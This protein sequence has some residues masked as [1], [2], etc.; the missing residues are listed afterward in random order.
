MAGSVSFDRAAAAYDQTRPLPE[1][2]AAHAIEVIL[3]SVGCDARLL[4]VGTG[5]G[6][7]SRPLLERGANLVGVD[8]SAQMLRR[9]QAKRPSA[10][11]AQAHARYLPFAAGSFDA[12]LTVHV[13]HVVGPWR[14]ALREFRRVLRP[15]G[16]YLDAKTYESVGVSQRGRIR[17]FWRGFMAAQGI[18]ARHP[19]VQSQEEWVQ[20]LRGLGA[21]VTEVEAARYALSFPLREELE[22]YETRVYSDTWKI[23]DAIFAAS[24]RE[25]RGWMAGKYGSL[26]YRVDDTVRCVVYVAR[27]EE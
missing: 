3:A 17:K 25:L 18:D 1:P 19:G 20:A 13:M 7:I 16:V 2:I 6:R 15:G 8:L 12:L 24:L 4:D 11:L 26:D 9:L 14:E 21:S 22:R 27:F 5:T 10:R 23:P